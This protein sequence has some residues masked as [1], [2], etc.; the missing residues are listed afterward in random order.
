LD[1]KFSSLPL[2]ARALI[3]VGTKW[4]EM[5]TA[6]QAVCDMNGGMVAIKDDKTV[7]R[8]PLPV[9]GLMSQEEADTIVDRL[10]GLQEAAKELGCTLK[11]PFMTLSFLALPVIPEL[12]VT[13]KGL[14]DV[15]NMRIVKSLIDNP[16]ARS[17][18]A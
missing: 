13:D 5:T 1:F 4:M 18:D 11:E 12:K 2:L 10:Q 17:T 14:V 6:V 15:K 9:A 3:V 7:A 16:G 8:L